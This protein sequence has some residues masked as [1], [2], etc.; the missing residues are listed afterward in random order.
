MKWE[1]LSTRT[2]AK[3]SRD[4]P[5][6]MNIAAIEQHGPHLPLATDSLVGAHFLDQIDQAICDDVLI[7]PQVKVCCSAHHMDFDGSLTVRHETLLRYVTEILDS[8]AVHGFRKLVLFN[9]HGGN[10][11]IGRVVLEKW[12]A[13]NPEARIFMFTWWRVAA[14]ELAKVQE[15]GFGGVGH[16]CEFETSLLQHFAPHLVAGDQ[17]R[18]ATLQPTFPWAENDMLNAPCGQLYRSMKEISGG[19]GV[20]GAPT[21]ATAAKGKRISEIVTGK[22]V[23][24]LTDIRNSQQ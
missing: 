22:L 4:L 23:S 12:G 7:L 14:S 6:V 10:E 17:I 24:M 9:S 8:V 19:S 20:V 11:A 1:L 5:V 2:L 21:F 16:A 3:I 18:E 15:S 13:A